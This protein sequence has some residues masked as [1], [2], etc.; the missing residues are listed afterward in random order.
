MNST[1]SARTSIC[2]CEI[3]L[4]DI[5]FLVHARIYK[6]PEKTKYLSTC[7]QT[8]ALTARRRTEEEYVSESSEK[9]RLGTVPTQQSVYP[10]HRHV[11]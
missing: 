6:N 3:C 2:V 1:V 8:G 4:G 7:Q 5:N 11:C 9:A 10:P